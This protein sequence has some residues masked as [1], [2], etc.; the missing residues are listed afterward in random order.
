MED[1]MEGR[2]EEWK[3]RGLGADRVEGWKNE[4]YVFPPSI[5]SSSLPIFHW[6][7]NQKEKRW[8]RCLPPAFHPFFLPSNL[9]LDTSTLPIFHWLENQKEKRWQRC[10]PPFHP[11]N[12]PLARKPE[13]KKVAEVSS[14]LPSF[15]SSIG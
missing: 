8:Q 1:W 7:E 13:G 10:L 9:P 6:I 11:F 2:M 12:L 4:G 3:G 15:Q 5:P 14:R